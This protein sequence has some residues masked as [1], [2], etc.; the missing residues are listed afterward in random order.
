[1]AFKP[2]NKTIEEFEDYEGFV[3]KFQASTKKTS[4]ASK[5]IS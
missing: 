1:M 5:N 3:K 4:K 2:A